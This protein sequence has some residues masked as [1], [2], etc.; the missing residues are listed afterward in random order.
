MLVR[1]G[2]GE[3]TLFDYDSVE[4]A[5]LNR[6]FFTPAHCGQRKVDAAAETL[7]SVNPD[8]KVNTGMR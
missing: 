2:I 4:P 8:T 1:C 7:R 3:L 6:L 5:N